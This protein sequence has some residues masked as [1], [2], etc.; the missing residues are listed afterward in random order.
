MNS[1][2][3]RF[4]LVL[5]CK[6]F[7]LGI[8]RI[9][10]VIIWQIAVLILIFYGLEFIIEYFK[11]CIVV[12]QSFFVAEVCLVLLRKIVVLVIIII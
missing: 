7:I 10:L 4:T 8:L 3:F 6:I 1:L 9:R 11:I 2:A 12:I 5:I